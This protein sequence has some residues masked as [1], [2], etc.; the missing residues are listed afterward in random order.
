MGTLKGGFL[1]SGKCRAIDFLRWLSFVITAIL[2][3]AIQKR[4]K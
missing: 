3:T 2:I 1:L 4:E